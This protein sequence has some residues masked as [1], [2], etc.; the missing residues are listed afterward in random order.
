MCQRGIS[1]SVNM[2]E[3][4]LQRLELDTL[5]YSTQTSSTKLAQWRANKPS[6]PKGNISTHREKRE[7]ERDHLR[8]KEKGESS[9]LASL[10]AHP[11]HGS[12]CGIK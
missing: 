3:L 1:V 7:Q 2:E 11:Y 6:V 8:G 5:E 12:P 9:P 4:L 10:A